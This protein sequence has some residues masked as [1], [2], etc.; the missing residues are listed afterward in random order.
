[1]YLINH[2]CLLHLGLVKTFN[3]ILNNLPSLLESTSKSSQRL[4][5]LTL[6]LGSNSGVRLRDGFGLSADHIQRGSEGSRFA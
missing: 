6:H 3:A 4:F 2:L 1:M 5:Q